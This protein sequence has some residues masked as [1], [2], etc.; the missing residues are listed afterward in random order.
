[1]L[2]CEIKHINRQLAELIEL[3]RCTTALKAM[4]IGGGYITSEEAEYVVSIIAN[5][6]KFVNSCNRKHIELQTNLSRNRS[7][8]CAAKELYDIL[9]TREG[10]FDALL[11]VLRKTRQTGAVKILQTIHYPDSDEVYAEILAEFGV[12]GDMTV[13]ESPPG[14]VDQASGLRTGFLPHR[15]RNS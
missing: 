13:F 8:Q 11:E 1:M 14:T 6:T 4:L 12:T 9:K 5:N 7:N 10:A 2:K 15:S 3:T